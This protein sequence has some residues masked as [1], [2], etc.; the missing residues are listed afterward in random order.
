MD[1]LNIAILASGQGSTL[2]AIC[3]SVKHNVL[4]LNIACILSNS[5]DN[6][7]N[8]TKIGE[9]YDIK[10]YNHPLNKE[11]NSRSQY[12]RII[13]D[14]LNDYDL[15][16]VVCAGWN[17]ILNTEFINSFNLVINLHPALPNTF[18][19]QNCIQKAYDSFQ[20]G[21]IQ[22][23][24][25]M[26]HQVIEDVDKGQVLNTINIP[27]YTEDSYEALEQRVKHGEKGMLIQTLQ[28]LVN[29][30]N[31]TLI[32]RISEKHS[33]YN[34]KVR[35]V[36]DIGYNC[37]ILSAS[38]RLSAFDKYICDVP[39]KGVIL[40]N[41]S[42][43]WFN[44]TRNIIDNH[45]LYNTNNHMIVKKT[46]P[47]KLEIIVRGY[48]TGSTNTSIWP[49]Y[50]KGERNIYGIN[51]RENYKKNEKL[52]DIIITPTT[53]GI[54]DRP[55]TPKEIIELM[56][57]SEEE[58]E[59]IS[60]KALELFIFG[61]EEASKKGLLLVDTKYEF[62]WLNDKIILIDELHTCDS[63][64]Y[65]LKKSYNDRFKLGLE[66]EK[67]DKDAIR[68]WVKGVCDPYKDD[69]PSIPNNVL[70]NVSNVYGEYHS[71]LT[72]NDI[73][74]NISNNI[75]K[76]LVITN[77]FMN[78]HR[79]IVVILAGSNKDEDHVKKIMKYCD[80]LNLYTINY[81]SS[82]H[83]NTRDVLR[84]LDIYEKQNR[85]IVYVTVAGRSNALSGVVASNT[86]F[87]TIACPPFKDNVDFQIN[88]NSTLICPSKV[89]VMTILEPENVAISINK[90][91]KI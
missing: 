1:K 32:D 84:I 50:N 85:K 55:I 69:I 17:Y 52:D 23:T 47:I 81:Y 2:K 86:R 59:F 91:F 8:I 54:T 78:H 73:S 4:N 31:Q 45:Y 38:D 14:S 62:G 65:W 40:N 12:N 90:I 11:L 28:I 22:F 20:R 75:S 37:L 19:G 42:V 58:W 76:D 26:V 27:I 63:S 79:E 39:N 67:F 24:G 87:P 46:R 30:F 82:A 5:I 10:V 15:D 56:Y 53:K 13:A 71:I 48:M 83:K 70:E 34:G 57:L 6:T 61:Q 3:D 64:R 9:E 88:I 72:D 35:C 80:Q 33:V 51:F 29:T 43:W 21:E 44:K 16:V 25:S 66:P 74:N 41:I 77:Y 36:E 60:N 18:I 49:M 89:P 68:D 7:N